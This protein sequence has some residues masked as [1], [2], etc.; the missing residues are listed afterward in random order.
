MHDVAAI[1]VQSTHAP[2]GVLVVGQYCVVNEVWHVPMLS[3]QPIAHVVALQVVGPVS[4]A[5][6]GVL[7]SGTLVSGVVEES[8]PI[9]SGVVVASSPLASGA[10]AASSDDA[11]SFAE[12]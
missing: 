1:V 4:A 7:A 3:Q 9:A 2:P 11:L 10:L 8:S 5:E 6:S 12:S